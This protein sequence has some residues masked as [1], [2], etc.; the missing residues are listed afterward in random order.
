M[1][2]ETMNPMTETDLQNYLTG[3]AQAA[4]W[5]GIQWDPSDDHSEPEPIDSTEDYDE[6]PAHVLADIYT[7]ALSMLGTIAPSDDQET[8]T[9]Y[10]EQRGQQSH[11]YDAWTL[12]GHDTLLSA[13]GHGT[14]LW[15]RGIT[16]GDTLHNRIKGH[17]APTLTR[18]TA[19]G[20]Y[21]YE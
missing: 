9:R 21:Y 10:A 5:T 19:T 20:D 18:D 14:G 3:Y 17:H 4:H 1:N 13:Q 12:L 8:L 11:E 6:L 7:D 15:D 16:E 2:T